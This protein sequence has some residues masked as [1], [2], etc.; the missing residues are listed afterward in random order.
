MAL[1]CRPRSCHHELF[2]L[3]SGR[4]TLG[5]GVLCQGHLPSGF[6]LSVLS[7][8]VS[9]LRPPLFSYLTC[10][11]SHHLIILSIFTMVSTLRCSVI[12]HMFPPVPNGV[13]PATTLRTF[14]LR[15]PSALLGVR[16]AG[17]RR[18][19]TFL[20]RSLPDISWGSGSASYG[21]SSPRH[22]F[23]LLLWWRLG[24]CLVSCI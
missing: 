2:W 21:R 24:H 3:F 1:P 9:F 18:T 11:P 19:V 13:C 16:F 12:I 4:Q 7:N 8:A 22:V 5:H 14:R 17:R 23:L 20:S 6:H 10:C 15:G